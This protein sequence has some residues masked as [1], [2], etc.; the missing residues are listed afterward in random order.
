M[1]DRINWAE[2]LVYLDCVLLASRKGIG[3]IGG[4]TG[5][6]RG[7]DGTFVSFAQHVVTLLVD[8]N[9]PMRMGNQWYD[10]LV[11]ALSMPTRKERDTAV[12][13]FERELKKVAVQAK[14]LRVLLGNIASADSL[15]GG[16]GR[17]MGN[18]CIALFMPAL[19][20][21]ISAEDR[22]TVWQSTVP[23]VFALAAYRADHGSYPAD[24]AALVPKYLPAIPEDL[25]SGGPLRYKGQRAGYVLYSVGPNGKDDGGRSNR[26]EPDATDIIDCDDITIRMPVPEK[27]RN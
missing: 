7:R 20:G 1:V 6:S 13:E 14:D 8:W 26:D 2:R 25:F 24:L 11:A 3:E 27:T 9:E 15:R 12:A 18:V 16:L 22:N 23:V 19:S 21:V 17:Q 10:R 4:L 5:S